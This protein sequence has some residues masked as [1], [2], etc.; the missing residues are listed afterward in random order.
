MFTGLVECTGTVVDFKETGGGRR[1][2]ISAPDY[3]GQLS[4]G[5]SV[6]VNGCCLTAAGFDDDHVVF[7]LLA[8]TLNCTNLGA[9][10]P[11]SR[12]N[13][14]R[15]M[16]ANAR[17]GGHFVQGHI[18]GTSEVVAIEAAGPDLGLTFRL[19]AD[20]AQY[21]IS[22]GSIAVNGVSLTVADLGADTFRVWIIPHTRELTNLGDLRT[23][24]L[25]NL[26]Y[27]VLAKYVERMLAARR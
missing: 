15:A 27:D 17:L 24:D 3:T 16:A 7:D 2:R 26:E 4:P 18:D 13:L 23:G 14:E 21:F 22:K 20:N 19:A 12:V 5:E 6:A 11:S 1:F 10:A 9:L 25:V 8:E